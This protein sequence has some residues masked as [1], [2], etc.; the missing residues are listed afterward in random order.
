MLNLGYH[1]IDCI[2][3]MKQFPD[4]YFDLAIVDP[5][6]GI[7]SGSIEKNG[8]RTKLAKAKDYPLYYGG[9]RTAPEQEYFDE[10]FRVSRNQI[11]WGA[12]HFISKMPKDSPCW[13]VWD[14][15][16]GGMSYADCEL[17]WTSFKTSVRKFDFRWC[18]MLQGD[19]KNKE[20][21]IHPH[22]KPVA[23][24]S[25]LLTKYAKPGD[26]ILD[27][28]CGSASSL[29][30]CHRLGFDFVGFEI[31]PHYYKLSNERL[32]QEQ[33]Q[34]SMFDKDVML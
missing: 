5:P 20:F 13:L 16:N 12:N 4:K 15:Q 18:G 27:T 1:N 29:L 22:Q 31:D 9:N 28:H 14:K 30:A 24:Y 26:K 34:V 21:R 11:I 10:L 17:G 32:Q 6:Y 19:M 3:G 23:L 7:G 2:Q 33:R 25:W 8:S